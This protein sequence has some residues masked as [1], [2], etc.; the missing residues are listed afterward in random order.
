MVD[1]W[2]DQWGRRL[3][4]VAGQLSALRDIAASIAK[5]LPR[6]TAERIL[7]VS[8]A[9][10]IE[11]L[12]ADLRPRVNP[13]LAEFARLLPPDAICQIV[14]LASRLGIE[15]QSDVLA[16]VANAS[17]R[18]RPNVPKDLPQDQCADVHGGQRAA[19][20]PGAPQLASHSFPHAPRPTM[21]AGTWAVETGNVKGRLDLA[22]ALSRSHPTRPAR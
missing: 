17:I 6:D 20:N 15:D 8:G 1:A 12:D 5:T 22:S 10:A 11:T 13:E 9:T 21:T 7:Q 2:L 19:R 14:H 3:E 16:E 4:D 18:E